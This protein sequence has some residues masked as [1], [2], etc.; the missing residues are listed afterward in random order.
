MHDNLGSLMATLKLNFQNLKRSNENL[1]EEE[2]QLYDKTDEMINEAYQKVRGL[3]HT[4]NAGVIAN[5]GLLPAIINIAKKAT[6]PGKLKI[7]VVP[8]GLDERLENSIEVNIFRMV[9][10]IITNAIKHAEASEIT[11][12]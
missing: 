5:E 9:Q 1:D 7:Q 10:E 4:K 12:N 8:F 2:A 6:I 11:I 3:A